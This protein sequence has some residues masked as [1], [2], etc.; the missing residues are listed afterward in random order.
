MLLVA[1]VPAAPAGLYGWIQSNNARSLQFFGGFALAVQLLAAMLLCIPLS[2]LDEAHS[3][4]FG[5]GGYL[6]RYVPL[7][8]VGSVLAF[9]AQLFWH[10]ETVKKRAGFRYVDDRDEPRLCALLEPLILETRVPVPFVAVV[11][12]ASRN[13]FACGISRKHAVIVV[14]RG[15]LTS[16]NDEELRAVLAHELT[17]IRNGDIRLMAAANI[18]M[19]NLEELDRANLLQFRHWLQ[20][21][22]CFAF[23][24]LFP[25]MLL[26]GLMS[27]VAMRTARRARY[28]I[29]SSREFV[30]D[31]RAAEITRNP[32]ALASALVRIRARGRIEG[33]APKDDAMMIS[34]AEHGTEATHPHIQRRLDA[35]AQVTGPLMFNAPG[36]PALEELGDAP[37]RAVFVRGRMQEDEEEPEEAPRDWLGLTRRTRYA[38]A[39]GFALFLA[40]NVTELLHPAAFARKFDVRSVGLAMGLYDRSCAPGVEVERCRAEHKRQVLEARR[41]TLLSLFHSAGEELGAAGTPPKPAAATAG[42]FSTPE[43]M[44]T[45]QD[46][47]FTSMAPATPPAPEQPRT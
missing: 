24:V 36:A 31:A 26:G 5:L 34:G 39:G 4:L 6:L 38:L 2:F 21:L 25:L 47:V 27:Q 8:L 43:P 42:T 7:I 40:V 12:S 13:A 23:P 3:P 17:H 22:F 30:A 10:M 33:L 28:A 20:I 16:L 35:L 32:A 19:S 46:G 18:C 41:G 11:E 9:G 15:L 45:E 1:D 14:T 29:T 37:R 44:V